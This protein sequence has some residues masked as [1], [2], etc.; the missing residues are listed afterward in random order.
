[1]RC[2]AVLCMRCGAVR[3][4]EG[5]GVSGPKATVSSYMHPYQRSSRTTGARREQRDTS[6]QPNWRRQVTI[7]TAA[8]IIHTTSKLFVLKRKT[9][10]EGADAKGQTDKYPQNFHSAHSIAARPGEAGWNSQ[11]TINSALSLKTN[12]FICRARNSR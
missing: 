2:G 9:K 7:C 4:R 5:D 8:K 10:K 12:K 3:C 1:M 6:V 11:N